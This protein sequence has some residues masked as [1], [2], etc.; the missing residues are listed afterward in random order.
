MM[1]VARSHAHACALAFYF[2]AVLST[3]ATASLAQSDLSA[4][5]LAGEPTFC[6]IPRLATD[7]SAPQTVVGAGGGRH[8]TD[9]EAVEAYDCIQ[10]RLVGAYAKAGHAPA[11]GYT[12]WSVYSSA[13]YVSAT[14]GNRYVNNYANPT[15]RAYGRF[16]DVGKLPVGSVLARTV[17]WSTIRAKFSL[18]R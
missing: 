14:H 6:S 1:S 2:I 16:E 12:D 15:A 8:L 7:G 11:T 5:K 10:E 3:G 17:L 13:P 18:A 9:E 4:F